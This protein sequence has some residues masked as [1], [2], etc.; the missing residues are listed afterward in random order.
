MKINE[1]KIKAY[2]FR[3]NSNKLK[4]RREQNV[5]YGKTNR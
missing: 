2:K 5:L 3:K 1:N 4:N